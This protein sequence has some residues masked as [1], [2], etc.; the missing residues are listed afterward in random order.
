[1]LILPISHEELRAEA[2][3]DIHESGNVPGVNM[4]STDELIVVGEETE[5]FDVRVEDDWILVNLE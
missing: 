1:M 5:R 4:A 3:S 2:Q